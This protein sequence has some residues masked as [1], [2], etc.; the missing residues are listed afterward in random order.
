MGRA[1]KG[2]ASVSIRATNVVGPI[3]ASGR[4]VVTIDQKVIHQ[5][6]PELEKLFKNVYRRVREQHQDS[7]VDKEKLEKQVKKIEAEAAK[8]E[9]ANPDKLEGWIRKLA[10]MAP[11]ILDVMAASLGGP[12]SGFTAVLKK[13]IE[14]ARMVPAKD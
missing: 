13:I 8:G 2:G 4:A 10:K 11:D 7:G 6:D 1:K 9:A 5:S 14:R 12:V 3:N